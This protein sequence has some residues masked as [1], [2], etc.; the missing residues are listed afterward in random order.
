MILCY[1][2][3]SVSFLIAFITRH[4]CCIFSLFNYLNIF[5]LFENVPKS[6]YIIYQCILFCIFT[7]QKLTSQVHEIVG[8]INGRF[9]TLSAVPIHH[10]VCPKLSD[11]SMIFSMHAFMYAFMYICM[12]RSFIE[13]S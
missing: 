5:F 9:G 4:D 13:L 11:E 12:C 6:I 7:D 2:I 8:R 3:Q 1:L 10:L